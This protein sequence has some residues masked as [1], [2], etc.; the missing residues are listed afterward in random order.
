MKCIDPYF[1]IVCLGF[2]EMPRF[3]SFHLVCF[4]STLLACAMLKQVNEMHRFLLFHLG[5][6]ASSFMKCRDTYYLISCFV[7]RIS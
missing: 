4:R 1:F 7:R 5:S 3:L 2:H 6:C